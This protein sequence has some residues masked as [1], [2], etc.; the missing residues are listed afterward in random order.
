MHGTVVTEP[1]G[2]HG[3]GYDPIFIPLGYDQTLGE[4]EDSVKKE[5]SHRS[6]ALSLAKKVIET[7]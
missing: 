1:R 5:L 7:L 4:L 6:Q 3:F 2:D